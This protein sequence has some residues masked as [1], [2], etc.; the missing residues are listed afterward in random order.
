MQYFNRPEAVLWLAWFEGLD[1]LAAYDISS[2]AELASMPIVGCV[3]PTSLA[4]IVT[5]ADLHFHL[6]QQVYI[7][8]F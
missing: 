8:M 1:T 7:H 5:T 6:I 2:S 4:A 3:S